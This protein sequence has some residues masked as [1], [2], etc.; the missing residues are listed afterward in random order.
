ME[1][2]DSGDLGPSE[3]LEKGLGGN[4]PGG[5]DVPFVD[6]S[7][8]ATDR[9]LIT[10]RGTGDGLIIRLNGLVEK[11]ALRDAFIEFLNSRRRFL[12]GNE[13]TF[14]WSGTLPDSS[15][16]EELSQKAREYDIEVKASSLRDVRQPTPLKDQIETNKVRSEQQHQMDKSK[17]TTRGKG[18]GEGLGIFGG[19]DPL[20][21]EEEVPRKRVDNRIGF[22]TPH[23]DSNVWDE[24]DARVLFATMRSGQKIE[25]EHS[26]VIVGD[27]NSGAELVAGGDI[28]VLGTL[29][30]VAHAGA[31]DESGGG[32][33]I[34]AL[35]LQPTQLRIGSVISRG[36]QHDGKGADGQRG[37]EIARAD[38]NVVVV[39]SYQAKAMLSRRRD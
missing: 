11:A 36:A 15:F 23:V 21:F 34:F 10:A 39:E 2:E 25:T 5:S 17:K 7:E 14:E 26:L 12:S 35:N 4:A 31:Y 28:I 24:A 3:L 20:Q 33:I 18:S 6:F 16:V 13:V 8:G 22:S 38:G 32:R 19:I 30:G 29:R 27:V 1:R 9:N 37:A